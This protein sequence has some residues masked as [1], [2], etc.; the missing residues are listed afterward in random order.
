MGKVKRREAKPKTKAAK[1]TLSS[2]Q[3]ECSER[4][5]LE[6]DIEENG[7]EMA[8]DLTSLNV[9]SVNEKEGLRGEEFG[10]EKQDLS[11]SEDF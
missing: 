7:K 2:S 3:E 9:L 11:S 8:K 5:G 4:K 6:S 1:A 10:L